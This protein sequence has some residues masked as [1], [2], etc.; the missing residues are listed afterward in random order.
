MGTEREQEIERE[1]IIKTKI[2]IEVLFMILIII[3]L[4]FF[5]K[6]YFEK[7][8]QIGKE[9]LTS[10]AKKYN[11]DYCSCFG[12]D[13]ISFYFDKKKITILKNNKLES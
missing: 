8:D 13:Y 11:L 12:E 10:G 6:G 2:I 4:I 9:P 5:I 3:I 7:L 1:K